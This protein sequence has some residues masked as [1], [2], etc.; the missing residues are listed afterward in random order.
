MSLSDLSGTIAGAGDGAAVATVVEQRV[1]R[2][3]QHSLFVSNDDVRR[4]ELE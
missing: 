1:D 4:F 2:F 3:L